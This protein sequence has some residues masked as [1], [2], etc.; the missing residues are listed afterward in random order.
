MKKTFKIGAI[1]VIGFIVLI[2]V[3]GLVSG[4]NKGGSVNNAFQQGMNDAK[5]TVNGK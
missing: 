2:V 4:G 3:I 1:I 5:Q